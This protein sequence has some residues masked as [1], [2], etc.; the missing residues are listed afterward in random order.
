MLLIMIYLLINIFLLIILLFY[1]NININ[2]IN[3]V[4]LDIK[5]SILNNDY[6]KK[7]N[8]KI[9]K[10]IEKINTDF[11]LRNNKGEFELYINDKLFISNDMIHFT[12]GEYKLII[13]NRI[14]SYFYCYKKYLFTNEHAIR[15]FVSKISE[16][17]HLLKELENKFEYY[18]VN[19]L[20]VI[21]IYTSIQLK[22]N[23]CL[24]IGNMIFLS[25]QNIR[26]IF[27]KL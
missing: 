19:L 21:F 6:Y 11:I 16:K 8:I 9:I 3:K 26:L 27:K 17:Y 24:L 10:L 1:Y 22:Y 5:I 4:L 14:I 13:N 18:V 12:N 15:E 20:F 2:N 25:I 23:Q 7:N